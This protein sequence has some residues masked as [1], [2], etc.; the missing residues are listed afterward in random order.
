MFYDPFST[1]PP[2]HTV[3]YTRYSTDQQTQNSTKRQLLNCLRFIERRGW[4][5]P[6][7]FFDEAV[8]GRKLKREGLDAMWEFCRKHPETPVI[9]EDISRLARGS[10]AFAHAILNAAETK[11][12]FYDSQKGYLDPPELHYQGARALEEW[13]TIVNRLRDGL[14]VSLSQGVWRG[15][16]PYGYMKDASSRLLINPDE[17]AVASEIFHRLAS[18]HRMADIARDLSARGIPSP[19]G[20]ARWNPGSIS[21][22]ASNRIY[23]GEQT[24]HRPV[25]EDE[26]K[27]RR[28]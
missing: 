24:S 21:A 10:R 18:K 16:P 22:I 15:E 9:I 11:A 6:V 5:A 4:A 27:V 8:S 20:M 3:C 19:S 17:A 2:E 12:F 28:P 7:H 25:L 26:R 13:R 23:I 1:N 14:C